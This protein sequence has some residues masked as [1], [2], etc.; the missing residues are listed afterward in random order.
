MVLSCL[1]VLYDGK[2]AVSLVLGFLTLLAFLRVDIYPGKRTHDGSRHQI[3]DR[4]PQNGAADV[5]KGKSRAP[6]GLKDAVEKDAW[7][8]EVDSEVVANAWFSFAGH[9]VQEFIYDT[10]YS[11]LTPDTEFPAEVRGL[12]NA[13]FG[14]LAKRA[15]KI[16]IK[17]LIAQML[18]M[19]VEQI[20]IFRD[21]K[22][23]LQFVMDGHPDEYSYELN[24]KM[25][26]MQLQ[27]DCN[28]HPS[29]RTPEGHYHVLQ[30]MA[31]SA[32]SYLDP[33]YGDKVLSRVVARELLSGFVFRKILQLCTPYNV[34][35]LVVAL[36]EGQLAREGADIARPSS[37]LRGVWQQATKVEQ[38]VAAESKFISQAQ[39]KDVETGPTDPEVPPVREEQSPVRTVPKSD[40]P[41]LEK[42]A[43]FKSRFKGKPVCQVVTAEIMN[44]NGAFVAREF[45]VYS[46]RVGD[47]RGEWTISRRYRHFEQL[48]RHMRGVKGYNA[49]LPPKRLFFHDLSPAYIESRRQ[50]L[51]AYLQKLLESPDLYSQEFVWEFFKK[52]SERFTVETNAD[53]IPALVKHGMGAV[54]GVTRDA[55][56]TVGRGARHGISSAAEMI[57]AGKKMMLKKNT[58]Q[59]EEEPLSQD[60]E[61]SL[62]EEI[63]QQ[64]STEQEE[65]EEGE[66]PDM[67]QRSSESSEIENDN[68]FEGWGSISVPLYDLIDCI[69]RLQDRGFF[70]KQVFILYKNFVQYLFGSSIDTAFDD[71]VEHVRQ[72]S[73]I[74]KAIAQLQGLLWPGGRFAM[75]DTPHKA[76]PTV[77]TYL[78]PFAPPPADYKEITSKLRDILSLG[79]ASSISKLVGRV[80]YISG[81]DDVCSVLSSQ[82]MV[83]QIAYGTLE[84]ILLHLFP[85]GVDVIPATNSC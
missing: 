22:E 21:A 39:G 73:V 43:T 60:R 74:A 50:A 11:H 1:G 84:L 75:S 42:H 9:I 66:V 79:P 3:K 55:T 6:M 59:N 8:K 71:L 19:V 10:W 77:E 52:R 54:V 15:K 62:P 68:V 58:K 37:E 64:P 32:I 30:R 72:E 80:A 28:L 38:F 51:D 27:K 47:N 56:H 69:F 2:L 14:R 78:E 61:P 65:E 82:T 25:I 67:S 70:R 4:F 35:K 31:D 29:M 83:C 18:E 5:K 12:F 13:A 33:V 76:C 85:E 63:H 24:E 44:S 34:Q 23:E 45:V 7:R 36:M 81:V 46:I 26:R 41:G 48:H 49:S 53:S 17:V 57:S 40:K 20:E 16:T